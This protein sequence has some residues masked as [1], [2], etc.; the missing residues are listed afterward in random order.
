MGYFN[1]AYYGPWITSGDDVQYRIENDGYHT[2]VYFQ[3]SVSRRD[4]IDNFDFFVV[5]Y[6]GATWL[7][8]R[9]FIRKYKSVSDEIMDKV[10][11]CK[12]ISFVG[13]SQGAALALLAHEDFT[14]R[15][16]IQPESYVYGCPRVLWFF[17]PGRFDGLHII[18]HCRDIVGRIPFAIMGFRHANKVVYHGKRGFPGIE[19]HLFGSYDGL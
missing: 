8:H 3:G 1:K 9:G 13:Y 12:S 15:F 2:I 4:W 10:K 5:P 19:Y 17:N 6:R 16:G 11:D 14:Y 7:A 18:N